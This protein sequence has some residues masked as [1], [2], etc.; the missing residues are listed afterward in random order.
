MLEFT[1][2]IFR[3]LFEYVQY[4]RFA[5]DVQI[6]V[7][8]TELVAQSTL[9]KDCRPQLLTCLTTARTVQSFAG[10][11]VLFYTFTYVKGCNFCNF[12]NYMNKFKYLFHNNFV[13]ERLNHL[14]NAYCRWTIH[15]IHPTCF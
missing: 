6:V 5:S 8:R 10:N 9:L 13:S 12:I 1:Q 3:N 14:W 2:E 7:W 4:S 11:I 15:A